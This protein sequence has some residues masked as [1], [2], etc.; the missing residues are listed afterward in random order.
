MTDED[1]LREVFESHNKI[2]TDPQHYLPHLTTMFKSFEGNTLCMPGQ[3]GFITE[4]GKKAVWEA[5]RFL[6]DAEPISELKLSKTLCK[7]AQAHADDT[8]ENNL[9]SHDGSDGTKFS[10]RIKRYAEKVRTIGENITYKNPINGTDFVL[11]LLIDDGV[12]S[13]GHRKNMFNKAFKY[14][15][16]GIAR[17]PRYTKC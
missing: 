1:L 8:E 9:I 5:G 6:K 17:H 11:D 16:I 12:K 2:R 14:V 7:A 4:E 13:R 15:G 3:V 10:V